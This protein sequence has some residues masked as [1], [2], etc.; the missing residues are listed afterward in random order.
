[1][2]LDRLWISHFFLMFM[3]LL[4]FSS[5]LLGFE[6]GLLRTVL[7]CSNLLSGYCN[8]IVSFRLL[9]SLIFTWYCIHDHLVIQNWVFNPE[10]TPPLQT[11]SPLIWRPGGA[12]GST[13]TWLSPLKTPTHGSASSL[14]LLHWGIY[15]PPSLYSLSFFII[16]F[17]LTLHG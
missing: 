16:I 13:R 12:R 11:S 17:Y 4:S 14:L 15:T 10:S 5:Y 2:G 8:C 3:L 6:V 9:G 7:G 1:M